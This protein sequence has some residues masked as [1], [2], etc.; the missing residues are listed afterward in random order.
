VNACQCVPTMLFIHV[1]VTI[2]SF[3][4]DLPPVQ[5]YMQAMAVCNSLALL[6]SQ[7]AMLVFVQRL[8][9]LKKLQTCWTK[10]SVAQILLP[11]DFEPDLEG[12]VVGVD[13]A[14]DEVDVK[15]EPDFARTVDQRLPLLENGE[16]SDDTIVDEPLACSV[17]LCDDIDAVKAEMEVVEEEKPPVKKT[18]LKIGQRTKVKVQENEDVKAMPKRKRGRPVKPKKATETKEPAEKRSRCGQWVSLVFLIGSEL[19]S[20]EKWIY[21]MIQM[22]FIFISFSTIQYYCYYY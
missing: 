7:S 16:S 22:S 18:S 9:V 20:L 12:E 3:C 19:N 1:A 8:T 14:N 4:V 15:L 10:G 17:V 21:N 6:A 13:S 2:L 11:D 5:K